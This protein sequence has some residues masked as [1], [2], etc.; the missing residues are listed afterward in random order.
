MTA[1]I[2]REDLENHLRTLFAQEQTIVTNLN[3]IENQVVLLREVLGIWETCNTNPDAAQII[4]SSVNTYTAADENP[5]DASAQAPL[6][7][8]DLRQQIEDALLQRESIRIQLEQIIAQKEL[9]RKILN[10]Q[11]KCDNDPDVKLMVKRV[12]DTYTSMESANDTGT[13]EPEPEPD[14]EPEPEPEPE[15]TNP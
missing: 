9:Y 11:I 2:T 14:P 15:P 4:K 3:Q 13:V 5:V 12:V 7:D 10:I 8:V 1:T 6:T